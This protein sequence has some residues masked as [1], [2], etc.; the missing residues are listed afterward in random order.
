MRPA[1]G[2]KAI[3]L[4]AFVCLASPALSRDKTDVLVMKNGDRFTCE[5]KNLENG[6]LKVE[7][8]YVDGTLSV[9]W[10]SVARLESTALFLVQLQD[11]STYS[12]KVIIPDT[13]SGVPLKIEILPNDTQESLT[14]D[15]SEIVRMTQTSDSFLHRFSGSLT[16]GAL[17][18][19]GNSTT[20]YNVGSDLD[21][22]EIRWGARLRY[23]S[24]LSS[25]T[26]AQT[27]TRNQVES[28]AFR[29]LP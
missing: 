9:D 26:G 23:S 13:L 19:K 10:L 20:Q 6:I 28:T 7:L 18:S 22:Q 29:L 25:S 2:I 11:G 1:I 4:C 14:V 16:I 12:G 5:V 24:N 27:S 21:Y 8:A 3:L 17:Y 15:K